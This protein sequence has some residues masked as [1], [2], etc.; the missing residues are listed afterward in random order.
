MIHNLL[1][2]ISMFSFL[3]VVLK[4]YERSSGNSGWS[5]KQSSYTHNTQ[6]F[7]NDEE[8]KILWQRDVIW[9]TFFFLY[10][11]LLKERAGTKYE[12]I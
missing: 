10:F 4:N 12:G 1:W 6:K 8:D 2:Q 5:F 9:V 11:Y 7:K 3:S